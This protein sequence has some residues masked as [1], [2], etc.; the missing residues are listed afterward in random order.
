MIANRVS[1]IDPSMTLVVADKARKMRLQG[2][3]VIS[4]ATGEPD[5]DT[6]DSIK[7]EAVNWI[8]TG[9]TKYVASTGIADLKEGIIN[10]LNTKN[11]LLYAPSEIIVCNG[12]KQAIYEAFGAILNPGDEVIIPTPC[13]VS[14]IE[15]VKLVDGN[16]VLVPTSENDNFR[17]KA[18]DIE[19]NITPRTKAIML[20]SPNNPTGAII[21]H[22]ELQKIAKMAVDNN[23]YIVADE[24]YEVL[25][26]R[27]EK[28]YSIASFNEEI[29]E[30]TIT[31]NSFSKSH[32]M[33]GWRI[34]YAAANAEVIKSMGDIHGHVTGNVNS[35]TQ[36]A[37]IE[38]VNNFQ[39]FGPMV[40][41]YTERRK[42]IVNRLNEIEGV[43]CNYPDGAFYVYPNVTSFFGK[44]YQG[45]AITNSL[46]LAEFILEHGH[47]ACVPGDAFNMGGYI[48]F[49]FAISD[50]K[51]EEGLDRVEEVLKLLK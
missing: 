30:L 42:Y 29:K 10:K 17:V 1:R 16:L 3:D 48:R 13:W 18:K 35:I 32:C 19:A 40:K 26:Y 12:A 51:I 44:E 33:T 27:E 11:G 45:K 24:V 6:P 37:A 2:M 47:V 8:N 9:F 22:N 20:N 36:K 15:Q 25:N 4:F 39:D 38:A 7:K 14:Y 34:G 50:G 31:I 23:I 43:K 28:I 41:K 49:T 5:F 21:N 46:E